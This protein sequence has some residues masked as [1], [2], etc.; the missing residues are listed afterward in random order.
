M[1]EIDSCGR[2]GNK[3]G[4]DGVAKKE[5]A[6]RDRSAVKNDAGPS[7]GVH[8]FRRPIWNGCFSALEQVPRAARIDIR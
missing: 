7:R 8:G 6:N 3:R 2:K 4:H 1:Q 5:W